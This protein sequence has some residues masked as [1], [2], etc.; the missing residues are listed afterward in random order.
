MIQ[1]CTNP[2]VP[3]H[4]N[5]GAR[6]IAVCP[7]WRESFAAF[8]ADMGRRPSS[9]HSIDRI[10]NDGNYEPGNCRWATEDEQRRN[11]RVSHF[12]TVDGES[13]TLSEWAIR[14][15]IGKSTIRERLKRGWTPKQAITVPVGMSK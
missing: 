14:F 1:R 4:S 8:L 9:E 10:N 3:C 2:N 13:A 15:R 5:Y 6:G 12:I 7:R 11:R